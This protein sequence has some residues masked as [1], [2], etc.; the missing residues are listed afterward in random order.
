M[1]IVPDDS[2]VRLDVQGKS[3]RFLVIP[4]D[5]TFSMCR[6]NKNCL[7][8]CFLYQAPERIQEYFQTRGRSISENE[9]KSI[10]TLHDIEGRDTVGVLYYEPGKPLRYAF[11]SACHQ[12]KFALLN[13]NAT[14]WQTA[15]GIYTAIKLLPHLD[16]G[17]ITMSDVAVSHDAIISG[18]LNELGFLIEETTGLI[19]LD[20]FEEKVLALFPEEAKR[21]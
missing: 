7:S 11:N 5:E 3:R 4:H 10:E 18:I 13:T 17:A 15:C 12:E 16:N 9:I 20:E 21:F 1:L 2:S 6:V 8:A 19:P 14:C